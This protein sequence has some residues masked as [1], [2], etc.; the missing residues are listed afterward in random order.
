MALMKRPRLYKAEPLDNFKMRLTFRNDSIYTVDFKLFFD[1]CKGL[2]PLRDPAEFAKA[3]I[4]EWGWTVEWVDRDIQIGADTLWL[5]AQAQNAPDE[6]TRLFA[7]WRSRYGLGLKQAAEA[8]GLT[9][10]T[11]SAYSS[12]ARPIPKTVQL[13][14][15]GWETLQKQSS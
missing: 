11:I 2:A 9:T 12:G 15:I 14:C 4:D 13:A 10:R 6:Q 7:G 3:T 8:L 5:D 1:E